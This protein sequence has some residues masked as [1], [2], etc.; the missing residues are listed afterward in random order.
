[1]P[2]KKIKKE[3]KEEEDVKAEAELKKQL[4]KQ[5]KLYDKSIDALNQFTKNE[6]HELLQANYQDIPSGR[7]EV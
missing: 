3:P 1:M 4:V 6:L 5:S 7:N 2:I